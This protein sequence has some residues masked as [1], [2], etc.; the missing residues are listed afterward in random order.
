[1]IETTCNWAL[2]RCSR[3]ILAI[4]I[5]LVTVCAQAQN[6]GET[7]A[8]SLE[9]VVVLGSRFGGRLVTDSPMPID[10]ITA[11]EL[12]NNGATELQDM[13]KLTVPSFNTARPVTAG[14]ADFLASPTLRGL[15]PGQVLVLVNGKRRHTSSD[16]NT[17][18]QIGRGDIAYDFNAIPSTALESV[19]VLRDGAS[20]QY[21]SDAI[22][23]VINLVLSDDLGGTVTAKSGVTT[24]GD[25][26]TTLVGFGYGLPLGDD[27]GFIRLTA[28]FQDQEFTDRARPDTRQQYFGDGGAT[29]L[30]NNF[31][32]GVG[33]TPSNGALDPREA[34]FNRN[35]WIFGQPEY[36]NYSLFVNAEAPLSPGVVAYGFGGYND[37]GGRNPNFFRRAGQDNTVRAIH[38][39]GFLPF[40]DIDL[41][42]LSGAVGLR[43]DDMAG[44]SWDLSTVYGESQTDLGYS[45][46]NNVSLGVDSP[47][48][49]D[50]G[51]TTLSQW[52]TNL[53]F[54]RPIDIGGDSPLNLAFGAEYRREAFEIRAGD[55]FSYGFG[56]VPILDGP[57][58]GSVSP[59]GAQPAGGTSPAEELDESRNNF[60][61]YGEVEKEWS[62][63]LLL[64]AAVRYEDYS[65]FGSTT[66]YRLAGRLRV[67]EVL[68]LRSSFGTAFR[69][70][71]L[72]Q[73][74]FQRVNTSFATGSPVETR[75]VSVNDPLAPL[76]GA[77]PL[78]PETADNF[79]VGAVL[80]WAGVTASVDYFRAELE[81]RLVL[82]SQFS[83]DALTTLLETN[84]FAGI[85]A[86]SYV[87]NAV[88]TTTDG[89]D[90]TVRYQEEIGPGT[91][92]ATFAANFVDTEFDRIAGTP[93][94]LAALGITAEL[95][96]LTQQVRLREGTPRDKMTLNLLWLFDR[97]GINL[98][99][100]R[101]G[102]VSQLGRS[103]QSPQQTDALL[104]GRGYSVTLVPRGGSPNVD[105]VQRFEADIVADLELFYDIN[106]ELT[107]ALGVSNLFN[108]FPEEQL[109]TTVE[110]TLAGAIGSDARGV[111]PY[112]YIA[113]F[114]VNG[115]F[116]YL[117][118]VLEF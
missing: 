7:T 85:G 71:A 107:V 104:S 49:F 57:N 105:I 78:E 74:F 80:E 25:G 18:N 72:P 20:A 54:S 100:T 2:R 26:W 39:D 110:S 97:W 9:E 40:Q 59:A 52:T 5:G 50:R 116:T 94:E 23:G 15:S 32:S 114:G 87:T 86:V 24:E 62:D 70:P 65:D 67:A 37:L 117:R 64:S 56:G 81:D 3:V 92:T 16:L 53:N 106:E 118:A 98:T 63:N 33:L 55:P 77:L 61:L 48:V 75:I 43:G 95:F 51:G 90:V 11:E 93:G 66:N 60:A 17:G 111:F 109:A 73:S 102:E 4:L 91:M 41:Q 38:P 30:S 115:R 42:N 19:E 6:E 84:G 68:T 113:P 12:T 34:T 83:S 1:M 47:T 112:A 44:F 14:V 108:N 10:L 69:A 22:A 103:N 99:A 13:L 35:I 82:S 36:T 101:Y 29:T 58:A 21:G 46:S 28:Q 31:G 88:D 8:E 76:I 79:S 89:V 96:D 27:G 45:N